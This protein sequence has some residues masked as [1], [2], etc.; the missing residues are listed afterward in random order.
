MSIEEKAE[1]DYRKKLAKK[2]RKAKED[3]IPSGGPT[4]LNR[5]EDG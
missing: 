3:K 1:A 4:S 5:K 2:A